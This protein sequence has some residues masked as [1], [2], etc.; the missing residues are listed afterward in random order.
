MNLLGKY[1]GI[2]ALTLVVLWNGSKLPFYW[3]GTPMTDVTYNATECAAKNAPVDC[4]GLMM[5]YNLFKIFGKELPY[6]LMSDKDSFVLPHTALGVCLDVFL[7]YTLFLGRA[8]LYNRSKVFLPMATVFGAMIFPVARGIPDNLANVPLNELLAGLIMVACAVGWFGMRQDYVR[9]GGEPGDHRTGGRLLLG[10]WIA[11]GVIINIAPLGEWATV[12]MVWSREPPVPDRP[13]PQSGRDF[14]AGF[15]CPWIGRILAM[16]CLFTTFMYSFEIYAAHM[17]EGWRSPFSK[18]GPALW[19]LTLKP[20]PSTAATVYERPERWLE[21]TGESFLLCIAVSW[22]IT[23]IFNP[24]IYK[25]NILRS[26]VGYNNLCVGFD[27]PPARYVAM[28]LLVLQAVLAG[29]YS[30]LDTIRLLATKATLTRKQFYFAYIINTVF[31]LWMLAFPMLLV[32][33]ADFMSWATTKIH[34]FLFMGTLFVMWLMIAG[35][36]YEAKYEDL[37]FGTKVWFFMFTAHTFLLPLTGIIDVLGFHPDLPPDQIYT[38]RYEKPHPPVP[39]PIT[40][41]LDYGWFMLLLLTIVFLPDAPPVET[42]YNCDAT[43]ASLYGKCA[44]E[45]VEE[46][47][48][49]EESAESDSEGDGLS[50]GVS[51][52]CA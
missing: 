36:V 27:S 49:A 37:T 32:I 7:L 3:E 26:I 47:S 23:S 15:G 43:D 52:A 17:G 39:W 9:N 51:G 18:H 25:V 44:K 45:Y 35:N 5:D 41:Y 29:R 34:L 22:L 30:Y 6:K 48:D 12:A 2:C 24:G 20:Y 11:I 38:I 42:I 13:H 8:G 31:A 1:A 19:Q 40:A 46:G 16:F 14:Y 4:K 50:D 33:T 28:P 10:S 21:A